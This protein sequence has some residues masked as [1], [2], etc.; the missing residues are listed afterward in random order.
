MGN[1]KIMGILNVTPDS[2]S[3][4][5]VFFDSNAAI[6]RIK[7][8]IG[9]GADI[10]DI[11]AE[12]TRPGATP[13]SPEQEWQRLSPVIQSLPSFAGGDFSIDTRHAQTARKLNYI[14]M[15][16]DVSGFA[17]PDMVSAVKNA[18]C[19]LVVMHSLSVPA[20]K[21]ITLPESEDV[22][23]VLIDFA[24]KRI[25]GLEKEGIQR[26][27]IIFDPG[28]GF[29]KTAK[30]SLQI[31]REVAQLKA[32]NVPILIGHSRKSCLSEYGDDR[33]AATL[34]VSQ[35]LVAQGVDY[36][37]VHDVAAHRKLLT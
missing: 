4:G 14:Y 30:Q 16:N 13:L 26:Q 5:R 6:A 1:T 12:S 37:R 22:M 34:E 7:T 25:A 9:E 24:E 2:F 8:L 29:G 23:Q 17:D 28:I 33:D 36:L 18:D 11:G 20:D 27:R 19:K 10:I 31:I 35:F 32:L 15:I 21:N 3:D